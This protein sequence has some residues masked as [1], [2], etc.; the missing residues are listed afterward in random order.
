MSNSKID[1]FNK[2]LL[3]SPLNWGW[4]HCTRSIA[5][6]NKLQSQGNQVWIATNPKFQS[7]YEEYLNGVQ[8]LSIEDY[9]FQFGNKGNFLW[10]LLLGVNGLKKIY[11]KEFRQVEEWVETLGVDLVLS[12]HRLGFRSRKVKS[13]LVSHQLNLSHPF[14]AFALNNIHRSL[15]KRFD[16]IWVPDDS[17]RSLSG[18]LSKSNLSIPIKYIGC[19]SRFQLLNEEEKETKMVDGSDLLV[20]SGPEPHAYNLYD[21]VTRQYLDSQKELKIVYVNLAATARKTACNLK[22]LELSSWK[23][24]DVEISNARKVISRSGYSTIMDL[25]VLKKPSVLIPTPGQ[26]EQIY[27]A[28]RHKKSPHF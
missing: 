7:V 19:L 21:L 8:F 13:V 23:D 22:H 27:L 4:G 10:D 6:L 14:F 16:E 17:E 15:L 11:K 1:V 28:T 12:D 18:T 26:G 25:T 5:L 20:V 24:L 2:T 9:P 3:F